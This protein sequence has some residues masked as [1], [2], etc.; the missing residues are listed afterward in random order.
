MGKRRLLKKNRR[1]IK[2][3]S[4]LK[5]FNRLISYIAKKGQ[6]MSKIGLKVD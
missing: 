4:K 3:P 5:S 2:A 1:R 6:I